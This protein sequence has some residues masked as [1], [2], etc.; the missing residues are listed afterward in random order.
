M[1][2]LK[3]YRNLLF[4]P[5]TQS[6]VH[7]RAHLFTLIRMRHMPLFMLLFMQLLSLNSFQTL[8][9][10]F[11]PVFILR[12]STSVL[13]RFCFLHMPLLKILSPC[14]LGITEAV[15]ALY[16][17]LRTSILSGQLPVYQL[18]HSERMP[19]YQ[20]CRELVV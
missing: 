13:P 6:N 1:S 9:I 10:C 20:N 4:P 3:P 5:M 17:S 18:L 12:E 2:Q 8:P 15:S 19:L 11:S 7:D 16:L 14:L